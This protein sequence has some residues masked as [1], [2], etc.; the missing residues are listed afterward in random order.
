[1]VLLYQI[2]YKLKPSNDEDINRNSDEI[3]YLKVS[4]NP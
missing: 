3:I 4:G 1:M 2:S